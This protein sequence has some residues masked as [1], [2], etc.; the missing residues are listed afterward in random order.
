MLSAFNAILVTLAYCMHYYYT[1]LSD[2]VLE[3]PVPWSKMSTIPTD[4]RR[5]EQAK[6]ELSFVLMQMILIN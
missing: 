1:K 4:R 2:V 5:V 3:A 6:N